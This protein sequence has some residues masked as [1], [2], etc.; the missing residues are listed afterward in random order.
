LDVKRSGGVVMKEEQVGVVTDF[1]A[2]PVVAGVQL[3][4]TLKVGD[5]IHIKGHSTDIEMAV[6]SIQIN[7]QEVPE[8]KSGDSIGIKVPERVRKGDHVYRIAS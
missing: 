5:S 7:R 3:I 6:Q 1:F 2:H 8:A 4:A